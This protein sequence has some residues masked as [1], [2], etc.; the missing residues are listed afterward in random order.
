[1]VLDERYAQRLWE[2]IDWL[3]VSVLLAE[4]DAPHLKPVGMKGPNHPWN[5]HQVVDRF[6]EVKKMRIVFLIERGGGG[7]SSQCGRGG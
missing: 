5:V 1:M 7:T 3:P 6:A 4:T 2:V